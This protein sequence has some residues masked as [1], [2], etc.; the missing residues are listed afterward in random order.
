MLLKVVLLALIL[1]ACFLAM[2]TARSEPASG[3]GDGE[4][5]ERHAEQED[6]QT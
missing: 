1:L 5:L 6:S 4:E 3:A 2:C